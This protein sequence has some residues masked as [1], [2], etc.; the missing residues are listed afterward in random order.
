MSSTMFVIN[1]GAGPCR[2]AT[3][4]VTRRNADK[5]MRR[6]LNDAEVPGR[7]GRIGLIEDGLYPYCVQ[8]GNRRVAVDMPGCAFEHFN[9][10]VFPRRLYVAGSS[11]IWKYAVWAVRYQLG[12]ET[13]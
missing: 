11:W 10:G 6:L 8:L 7:F 9:E 12:L 4:E 2:G 5:N 3:G 1:P 13:E